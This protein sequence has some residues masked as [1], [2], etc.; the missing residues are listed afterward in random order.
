M[1]SPSAPC[2][3]IIYREKGEPLL[4]HPHSHWSYVH[5]GKVVIHFEGKLHSPMVTRTSTGKSGVRQAAECKIIRPSMICK[6]I[7]AELTLS[8]QNLKVI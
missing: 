7:N 3:A 6:I 2:S 4:F 1:P 8:F 5:Q